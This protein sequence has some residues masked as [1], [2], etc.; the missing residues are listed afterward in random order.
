MTRAVIYTRVSLDRT[1]EL[2]A[3]ERQRDDCLAIIRQRGWELVAEYSDNSISASKRNVKRPEYDRMVA[4]YEAGLFDALVCWDLDRLTRQPRQ[5]EDWIDRASDRGLKLT[6]ANGEADLSTDA[7]RLFARIKAAVSLEEVERKGARQRRAALQRAESGRPTSFKPALGYTSANVVVPEEA[8]V[9]RELFERFAAGE[10]VYGLT[11]WMNESGVKPK[12]SEKWSRTSV[13]GIL[14]NPRYAARVVHR[15][16][17]VST[18]GAW[19]PIVTPGLFDQVAAI[20]SDPRRRMNKG[21]TA[22]RHLLSNI[23]KCGVCGDGMRGQGYAYQCPNLCVSKARQHVDDIVLVA[24]AERLSQIDAVPPRGAARS[25]HDERA[26]EL[27]RRLAAI[28]ADYDEGLIDGRRFAVASEKVQA[29]LAE[30]ERM[31]RAEAGDAAL[32]TVLGAA[33]PFAAFMA[34][35]LGVRRSVV[36]ALLSVT[37]LKRAT[38]G[39]GKFDPESVR[40]VWKGDE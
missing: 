18:P 16:E 36:D 11:Q 21:R 38:H 7:G 26:V 34:A 35:P 37:L 23:A 29:E 2:L 25:G 17:V 40:I 1:G 31:R 32:S 28:E 20:L 22:R 12:Q 14:E 27:R 3:V 33:D 39:A 30:V 13:R 5:L 9:V 15:G 8:A 24:V 4:D 10:T 6:T 19:E